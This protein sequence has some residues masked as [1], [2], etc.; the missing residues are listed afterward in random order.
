VHH[1]L[2]NY[3]EPDMINS[4]AVQLDIETIRRLDRLVACS[5]RSKANHLREIIE[6]GIQCIEDDHLAARVLNGECKA[7]DRSWASSDSGASL[8]LDC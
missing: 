1:L 4:I 2:D 8:C 7:E 3:R 6:R 5:G